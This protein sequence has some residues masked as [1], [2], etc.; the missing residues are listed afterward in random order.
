MTNTVLVRCVYPI[1][2]P[3]PLGNEYHTII[4]DDDE[5]AIVY[6]CEL[7]EGEDRTSKLGKKVFK[8]GAAVRLRS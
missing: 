7:H 4:N 2:K 8:K 5:S 3:H 6:N 1:Q